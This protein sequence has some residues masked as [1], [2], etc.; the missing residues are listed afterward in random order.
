MHFASLFRP[1]AAAG[2][3]SGLCCGAA[4]A[5]LA[6]VPARPTASPP[7]PLR[8][9]CPVA[10]TLDVLGDR[11]TL[12]VVRDLLAGKR[13]FG[14]FLASPEG[15]PTNILT[16]RLKRLAAAGLVTKT[17]YQT[18]PVR[19]EYAPTATGRDLR[20]VLAAVRRWAEAHLPPV[21]PRSGAPR[22]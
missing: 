8:S 14:D 2:A 7:A 18:N 19:H 12:L 21:P 16:D 20:G 10:R 5:S 4:P 22:P 15:I 1:P 3:F 11:W 6:A 9:A 17:A 13:R